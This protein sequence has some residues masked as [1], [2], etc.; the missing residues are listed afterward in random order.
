MIS[1]YCLCIHQ[2]FFI[3]IGPNLSKTVADSSKP[4]KSSLKYI[5]LKTFL[6][7]PS[8]EDGIHKL[9]SQLN[10]RK[11]LGPLLVPVI[12]LKGNVDT[13]SNPLGFI[14]KPISAVMVMVVVVVVVGEDNLISV[15]HLHFLNFLRNH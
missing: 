11:A 15:P 3:D 5:S 10:K 9:A 2:F 4:F 6:F 14:I 8:R 7:N 12:I 1:R 13:L